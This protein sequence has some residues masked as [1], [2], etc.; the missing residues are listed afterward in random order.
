[1]RWLE[2]QPYGKYLN[3]AKWHLRLLNPLLGELELKQINRET[4]DRWTKERLKTGV[5]NATVNR[6]LEIVRAI[7]NAAKKQWDWLEHVPTVRM[8]P[9]PN[10]RI[11]WL[12]HEEADRMIVELPEHLAA[13]ARFTLATGLRES[14][15]VEL[16]WNQVNLEQHHAWIH[17]DQTKGGQ[18]QFLY[19]LTPMRWLFC[20]SNKASIQPEFSPTREIQ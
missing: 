17:A 10:R 7:L 14:N 4:L 9:K 3:D 15:V 12:T 11:R 13:M 16:E 18:Q 19:R 6:T 20:G 8:L 1:V 2:E 5:A